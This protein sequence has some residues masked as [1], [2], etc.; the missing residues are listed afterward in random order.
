MQ[1]ILT[2]FHGFGEGNAFFDHDD[3]DDDGGDEEDNAD[4]LSDEIAV[5]EGV[6]EAAGGEN[7][8]KRMGYAEKHGN[9]LIFG[10]KS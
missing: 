6:D 4:G 7:G 8:G 1:K 5:G 10:K 9:D 3:P 2:G